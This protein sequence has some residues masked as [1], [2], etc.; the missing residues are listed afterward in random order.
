MYTWTLCHSQMPRPRTIKPRVSSLLYSLVC[1]ETLEKKK[2]EGG[3]KYM[4]DTLLSSV[5]PIHQLLSSSRGW[6]STS[7]VRRQQQYLLLV[8]SWIRLGTDNE[9]TRLYRANIYPPES[10]R[11]WK[12]TLFPKNREGARRR[13]RVDVHSPEFVWTE[14]PEEWIKE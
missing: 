6:R 12:K 13:C 2:S 8:L 11:C 4:L 9:I 14:V 3:V 10:K 1:V 5:V 7:T